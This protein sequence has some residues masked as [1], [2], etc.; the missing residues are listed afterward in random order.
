MKLI[1]VRR[2]IRCDFPE[3]LTFAALTKENHGNLKTEDILRY[4]ERGR[5]YGVFQNGDLGATLFI[6]SIGQGLVADSFFAGVAGVG[7]N[8]AYLRARDDFGR[9]YIPQIVEFWERELDGEEGY[10]MLHY[11][12]LSDITPLLNS[13]ELEIVALRA[14]IGIKPCLHLYRRKIANL[15]RCYS[16]YMLCDNEDTKKLSRLLEDGFRGIGAVGGNLILCRTKKG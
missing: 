10:V 11:R 15:T 12:Y 7:S 14:G 6:G 3:I 4:L 9:F 2:L 13:E 5:I 1:K 8:S 16:E